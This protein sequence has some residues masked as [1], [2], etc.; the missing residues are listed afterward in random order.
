MEQQILVGTTDGLHT[1]NGNAEVHLGGLQV[2]ALAGN[3]AGWWCAV[4][5]SDVWHAE[6]GGEWRPVATLDGLQ[7][8]CLQ[9]HEGG[10]HVGTSE[11][12]VYN[13][14][15]GSLEQVDSFDETEEQSTWYTPWG[16]PPDVRSMSSEPDGTVYANVHVGGVVR[17]SDGGRTWQPTIDIHADVHQVHFDP[18]SGLVLAACAR[19]LAVSS[20]E[21]VTW[22]YDSAGLHGRYLRAVAVANG[23]VLVAA[24]TGPY[25]DRGA[26]YRRP[27]NSE[28]PFKRCQQGLPEWFHDNVDTLCLVAQGPVAAFGTSQGSVFLSTDEGETWTSAAEGLPPVRCLALAQ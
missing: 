27:L 3:E 12:H 5:E 7:A 18:R 10:V 15:Q 13:L 2:K 23:T 6:T 28:E 20:D 19:G 16:G 22:R 24:S 26:V 8:N 9:A 17:S 4:E 1:L 25:T 14:R 11:A 21:G